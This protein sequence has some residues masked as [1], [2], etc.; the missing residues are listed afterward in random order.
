MSA[1][2]VRRAVLL[3][4]VVLAASGDSGAETWAE[5]EDGWDEDDVPE[6]G[7]SGLSSWLSA[8]FLAR[9]GRSLEGH[10]TE[11]ARP[12]EGEVMAPGMFHYHKE[13]VPMNK[14]DF[15]TFGLTAVGL[16]VA[17]G[18]G[19]G[20]G[21]IIVPLYMLVLGFRPKHAIALSNLTIFGGSIA[22]SAFNI[23]KKLPDGRPTIDWDIIVMMEPSTIA[24]AVIGSFMSKCL[25][26][27]VLT[28]ALSLVLM[29]LAYR[30]LGK[31]VSMFRKESAAEAAQKPPQGAA[32]LRPA[33]EGLP[34]AD[35][36]PEAD[37]LKPSNSCGIPV[38]KVV[39]LAL[40]FAGC[41]V[42]TVL[43]GSGRG[44]II[45]VTCGSISFW[46]LAIGTVPWVVSFGL[47][48]R[49]VL[50]REYDQKVEAKHVFRE[51]EIRWDSWATIKYPA[52]CTLAGLFAGL[53]GV[54]GGIVKG[55]LMLE[56]GVDPQVAAATAATMIFFTTSAACVSFFVFGLLEAE[57]G[58][59]LF[60]LGLV[61][62]AIGQVGFNAWMQNAKR[63]SPP[64]LSI[65][66]V[67]LFSSIL[68]GV[69]GVH[70][71]LH[72]TLNELMRP[73]SICSASE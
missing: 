16:L 31:G 32:A 48:F 18:G 44:S 20:G 46:I 68:V 24:G 5:V 1:A 61:L 22:N 28:V 27:F 58:I 64:V 13:L 55:P 4:V 52:L 35:P 3:L 15:I 65:G 19:I 39:L 33:Y 25:P 37:L 9:S 70:K 2:L 7:S 29:A 60:F 66:A 71:W 53:F 62:T 8:S 51:N 47:C 54:G 41:V 69:E 26:D 36:N 59:V 50:V 12:A 73:S 14:M 45:G 17:S 38:G 34:Q 10:K 30:T 49:S 6:E 67:L 56:M 21:G 23:W 63:K 42:L 72:H 57:Y 11:D 43:K 40:C